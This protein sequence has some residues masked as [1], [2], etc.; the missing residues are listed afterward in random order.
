MKRERSFSNSPTLSAQKGESFPSLRSEDRSEFAA[1]Q[2][3]LFDILRRTSLAEQK[4][5]EICE[6]LDDAYVWVKE[7]IENKNFSKGALTELRLLVLGVLHTLPWWRV[8]ESRETMGLEVYSRDGY[9]HDMRKIT[10]WHDRIKVGFE[11]VCLLLMEQSVQA[12]RG[13]LEVAMKPFRIRSPVADGAQRM[14]PADTI[15]RLINAVAVNYD[16]TVVLDVLNTCVRFLVPRWRWGEKR[17]HTISIA[18][19]LHLALEAHIPLASPFS[20]GEISMLGHSANGSARCKEESK[21][22]GC[23]YDTQQTSSRDAS[24]CRSDGSSADAGSFA[25]PSACHPQQQR[26]STGLKAPFLSSSD[27]DLSD[28][29]QSMRSGTDDALGGS[30][31]GRTS[32]V[33]RLT[34]TFVQNNRMLLYRNEL[35]QFV[36]QWLLD[37]ELSLQA[38]DDEARAVAGQHKNP[39]QGWGADPN[40]SSTLPSFSQSE[41]RPSETVYLDILRSCTDL[42]F[43][44]LAEDLIRQR[45]VGV[46]GSADWWRELLTFHLNS[47]L[48]VESPRC[49]IYLAPSLA[50]LG[51]TEEATDM[52]RKF[53][54]LVTKG[55]QPVQPNAGCSTRPAGSTRVRMA[56]PTVGHLLVPKAQ[57]TRAALHVYPLFRFM[58]EHIHNVEDIR[59]QL[60]KCLLLQL[61]RQRV[62][63]PSATS[64]SCLAS[65][66]SINPFAQVLFAQIAALS[67]LLELD[68][69]EEMMSQVS[70]CRALKVLLDTYLLPPETNASENGVNSPTAGISPHGGNELKDDV[71]GKKVRRRFD[72]VKMEKV[73]LLYPGLM[74]DCPW[75]WRVCQ[76]H[77]QMKRF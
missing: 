70:G 13:V 75:D 36:L 39:T 46:C 77:G 48:M 18:L 29:S 23:G 27:A 21:L 8:F 76:G 62:V 63:L 57:R 10:R 16:G 3:V 44:R 69:A 45:S 34:D 11:R 59:K 68:A 30:I 1:Q 19:F 42:V 41:I 5:R 26:H 74:N 32:G 50:L 2:Q 43:H 49:L 4:D 71:P 33:A 7:C 54:V 40:G 47:V 65:P 66:T 73:G 55:Y 25:S 52:Y 53:I 31:S 67:E 56:P 6:W 22:G 15:M 72:L 37:L 61:E 38:H 17:H 12:V 9:R 14:V 28:A 58:R 20:G 64:P 24:L 51:G 60:H 35:I